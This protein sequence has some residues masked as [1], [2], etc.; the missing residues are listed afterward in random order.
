MKKN[1][2]NIEKNKTNREKIPSDSLRK[3]I[4]KSYNIDSAKGTEAYFSNRY[5]W[6]LRK[7]IK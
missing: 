7:S 6:T 2:R 4:E 3:E 1:F 5:G